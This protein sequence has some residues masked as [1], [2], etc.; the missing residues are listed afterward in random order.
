MSDGESPVS[1]FIGPRW[2]CTNALSNLA[3]SE[4]HL[5]LPGNASAP[6]AQ[7]GVPFKPLVEALLLAAR[8]LVFS[9]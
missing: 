1:A 4:R 9:A 7:D 5:H 3:Q 2:P 6:D 8:A